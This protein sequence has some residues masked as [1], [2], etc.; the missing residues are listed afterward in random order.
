MGHDATLFGPQTRLDAHFPVKFAYSQFLL[1][2]TFPPTS[3]LYQH[4]HSKSLLSGH[5][6]FS[7]NHLSPVQVWQFS[8]QSLLRTRIFL[9]VTGAD[10]I[11]V[12]DGRTVVVSVA[13]DAATVDGIRADGA[14]ADRVKADG[15]T[16]SLSPDV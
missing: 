14:T 1:F 6:A 9:G 10:C 5:T 4:S 13:V 11:G 3:S 16:S 7:S 15:A 12:A 2:E 8:L